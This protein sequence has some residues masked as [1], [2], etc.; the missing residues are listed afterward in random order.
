ML[1]YVIQSEEAQQEQLST[2]HK[3]TKPGR[4]PIYATCLFAHWSRWFSVRL[5]FLGD[6][7]GK[8]RS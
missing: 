4:G 6:I 5:G 3:V 2:L 8:G 1:F 7:K